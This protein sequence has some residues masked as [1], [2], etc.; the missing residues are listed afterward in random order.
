MPFGHLSREA[1]G[2]V[3]KRNRVARDDLLRP[4]T[5]PNRSSFLEVEAAIGKEEAQFSQRLPVIEFLEVSVNLS[6]LLQANAMGPQL[7]SDL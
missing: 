5:G 6:N 4:S 7:G 2:D 1:L 3:S